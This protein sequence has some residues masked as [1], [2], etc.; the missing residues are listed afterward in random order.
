MR[1]AYGSSRYADSLNSSVRGPKL[2]NKRLGDDGRHTDGLLK[3]SITELSAIARTQI[4]YQI[5]RKKNA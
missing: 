4:E 5:G 2:E 3:P 1:Q